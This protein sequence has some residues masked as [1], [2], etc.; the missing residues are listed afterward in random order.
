MS[1]DEHRSKFRC[2]GGVKKMQKLSLFNQL[3]EN[4]KLYNISNNQLPKTIKRGN[5]KV[6][7]G[8]V[9]HLSPFQTKQGS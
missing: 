1:R 7:E 5:K 8:A 9:P 2:G 3:I 4:Q 6:F